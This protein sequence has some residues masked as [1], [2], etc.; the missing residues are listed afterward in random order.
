MGSVAPIVLAPLLQ[1]VVKTGLDQRKQDKSASIQTA[2]IQ[3]Q[4][5]TDEEARQRALK[6][7]VAKQRARF[8]A[9]GI[10][11]DDGSA[12]AVL[13]GLFQESEAES[14]ARAERDALRERAI[15]NS[16]SYNS[17]RNLLDATSDVLGSAFSRTFL[18]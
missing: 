6:A 14:T 18:S 13:L 5:A 16:S 1:T 8:A 12:E 2:Q 15:G 4:A 7:S 10:D 3:Q 17:G 9:S 11:A